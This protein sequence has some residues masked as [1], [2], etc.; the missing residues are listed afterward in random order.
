MSSDTRC[1]TGISARHG[2]HH[3][4]QMFTTAG[5]PCSAAS[6]GCRPLRAPGRIWFAWRCRAASGGGA[7]ARRWEISAA[8]SV[9][10][11]GRRLGAFRGLHDAQHEDHDERDPTDAECE[12]SGGHR[13]R[14]PHEYVTAGRCGI[15]WHY[16]R[17]GGDTEC[18]SARR[19]SRIVREL[20]VAR[21]SSATPPS[22]AQAGSW[23]IPRRRP[24]WPHPSPIRTPSRAPSTSRVNVSCTPARM[25]AD[26]LAPGSGRRLALD[27]ALAEIDAG[28][29]VPS[30]HWRRRY[31]L[32]LGLE[33]VLSEDEPRLADGTTLNPHQVDALSGTLTALLAE[34]Q[35]DG[36]ASP[37]RSPRPCSPSTT[38]PRTPSATTPTRTSTTTSSTTTTRTRAPTRSPRPTPT[39]TSRPTRSTRTSPRASTT[40]PTPT[41]AS[42]S[43]TRPAP[44]RPS[45]RWASSRPRAPAAS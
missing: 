40:T 39:R 17:R 27:A 16:S 11:C 22:R 3:A 8:L 10:A 33:R 31:S 35:R 30:T 9:V 42:G 32:L 24:R 12:A 23:L 45:P 19:N 1:I 6:R 26:A 7:P 14:V 13:E 38:S 21:R 15:L 43:S 41:S 29:T 18:A 20:R 34:A 25:P 5:W 4:A 36:S 2:P 37:R 44:A 28:A